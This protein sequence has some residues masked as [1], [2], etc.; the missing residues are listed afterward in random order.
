MPEIGT[1]SHGMDGPSFTRPTGCEI[2]AGG[3]ISAAK[4][5]SQI[6]SWR[7]LVRRFGLCGG[8]VARLQDLWPP[9]IRL[10]EAARR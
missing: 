5:H 2:A 1:R 8:A 9:L 3:F 6:R 4:S 7:R 10:D